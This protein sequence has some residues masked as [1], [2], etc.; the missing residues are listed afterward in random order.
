MKSKANWYV[1]ISITLLILAVTVAA[2]ACGGHNGA[3]SLDS[4]AVGDGATASGASKSTGV[5]IDEEQVA[6]LPA[7]Q[8][9]LLSDSGWNQPFI[10]PVPGTEIAAPTDE[11]LFE[12]TERELAKG[13]E[14]SP[15]AVDEGAS[16]GVDGGKTAS[17]NDQ[18]TFTP[19]VTVSPAEYA[20]YNG[21]GAPP[22][23]CN[24][25]ASNDYSS[26]GHGSEDAIRAYS[27]TINAS[28]CISYVLRGTAKNNYFVTGAA[29]GNNAANAVYQLMANS[30][31]S[32][33]KAPGKTDVFAE[34]SY[35]A[36][37]ALDPATSQP[38]AP[39]GS[40]P[41]AK[42]YQ[43]SGVYWLRFNSLFDALPGGATTELFNLLIAPKSEVSSEFTSSEKTIGTYQ[44]FY[45][46][47]QS[48]MYKNAWIVGLKSSTGGCATWQTMLTQN[49]TSGF[50]HRPIYGVLL[51]RW[52]D[53]ANPD[54]NGP[55]ES[56]FG[57]PVFG[58]V[59]LKSSPTLSSR[60]SYYA[61]GMWFERG[62]IWWI[63]YDQVRNPGT[64]DEAQAFLYTG[65]NV[66]C[67]DGEYTAVQPTLYYGANGKL[68]VGVSVDGMRYLGTDPWSP[69]PFST[70]N[71]R[72]EIPLEDDGM[73]TVSV[74]MHAQ[75]Y[76]GET[77]ASGKYKYYVW[78]FRDGLINPAGAAYND[79]NR[80]VQH[81]YGNSTRNLEG[82]YVVRVQ[83]TDAAFDNGHSAT[84]T[85]AYGDSFPIV[86]GHSPSG[87]SV[88]LLRN[89]GGTYATN[90]NA[91]KADLDLLK[92]A[93][94][95]FNYTEQAYSDTV[96]LSAASMVIWYRGGPAGN[97]GGA[98]D[99]R[100]IT[101]AEASKL[102]A[103]LQAGT[104]VLMF[105]QNAGISSSASWYIGAELQSPV[106][107]PSIPSGYTPQAW[108]AAVGWP[109]NSWSTSNICPVSGGRGTYGNG[110]ANYV[111]GSTV[112]GE[113]FTGTNSS[114]MIPSGFLINSSLASTGWQSSIYRRNAGT[115]IAGHEH[116]FGFDGDPCIISWGNTNAGT[117]N[118]TVTY[119]WNDISI[120]GSNPAGMTRWQLLQNIIAGLAP[121]AFSGGTGEA[122]EEYSGQPE[123]M[124]VQA[125]YYDATG[126]L[127]TGSIT[128]TYTAQTGY[129]G[130][131]Y[132]DQTGTNV[133]KTFDAGNPA[134][135]TDK[136]DANKAY[137]WT[138]NPHN[139][140]INGNDVDFQFPWYAYVCD[141]DGSLITG[142]V[143]GDEVLMDYAGL[144][145]EDPDD[146][147]QRDSIVAFSSNDF[148]A[149]A[150]WDPLKVRK[151]AGYYRTSL[152]LVTTPALD[153]S[154]KASYGTDMPSLVWNNEYPLMAEA[155]A[156]WDPADVA[157]PLMQWSVFPGHNMIIN[158]DLFPSTTNFIYDDFMA[159][160][161]IDPHQA[162]PSRITG[163]FNR[164]IF[165]QMSS[166][167]DGRYVKWD[168]QKS[169]ANWFA[170]FNM[171]GT[172][173]TKDKFPVRCRLLL[174]NTVTAPSVWPDHMYDPG[175]APA[176]GVASSN[177]FYVEGGCYVVD[178]GDK[179]VFLAIND[180]PTLPDPVA[181][182][183]Y[184]TGTN[185][186]EYDVTLSYVLTNVT[187][188][189]TVELD[190]NYNGVIFGSD[191]TQVYT[192][193]TGIIKD[194]PL[195]DTVTITQNTVGLFNFAIRVTDG[196]QS[197][198]Y[199][200]PDQVVLAGYAAT[201]PW[202]VVD[203]G[204]TPGSTALAANLLAISPDSAYGTMAADTISASNAVLNLSDAACF[205]VF[206]QYDVVIWNAGGAS[207]AC[208]LTD[209]QAKG[210]TEAMQNTNLIF[211]YFNQ[212]LATAAVAGTTNQQAFCRAVSGMNA[213]V[214]PATYTTAIQAIAPINTGPGGTVSVVTNSF[215]C[216]DVQNPSFAASSVQWGQESGWPT[217][218][219]ISWN[220]P[221]AG[222]GVF[223]AS[224]WNN[225]LA[226]SQQPLLF[227][228]LYRCD[229]VSYTPTSPALVVPYLENFDDGLAQ[230]WAGSGSPFTWIVGAPSTPGSYPAQSAPN[231]LR[232]S[233]QP[234]DY[235]GGSAS[236]SFDRGGRKI[237][238]AGNY[239]VRMYVSGARETCCDHQ[240]IYYYRNGT[241][242]NMIEVTNLTTVPTLVEY[243]MM[244]LAV[245]DVINVVI[246]FTADSSVNAYGPQIDTLSI[247][248]YT[249]PAPFWTE[250]FD[251]MPLGGTP[252]A[253]TPSGAQGTYGLDYRVAN[254]HGGSPTYNYWA[255]ISAGASGSAQWLSWPSV[256]SGS[257]SYYGDSVNRY[258]VS[259]AI[260]L[261]AHQNQTI[262]LGYWTCGYIESCCDTTYVGYNFSGAA[263]FTAYNSDAGN[264]GGATYGAW[265]YN[266]LSFNSGTNANVYVVI[267]FYSDSSVGYY[268]GP[269]FD[270]FS[271]IQ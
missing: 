252:T 93:G 69:V 87:G 176:S 240:Y 153:T 125:S 30:E 118:W 133:Y 76:G 10:D 168:F 55:W 127:H 24:A 241:L 115:F 82:T 249:P 134:D 77:N 6:S 184:N 248:L 269:Q 92:D 142:V 215:A 112:L 245:N 65:K 40:C 19:A 123:I 169:S 250:G 110:T 38:A 46:G 114:G 27:F 52:Q 22:F 64:P 39:G 66:Y 132:P 85:R 213:N 109:Y 223:L 200:Y 83:V 236:I 256:I 140:W 266:T 203:D 235:A 2:L 234:Y 122:F 207:N 262:T 166:D 106:A 103:T 151:V 186:K 163:P 32:N 9:E 126:A 148:V 96:N 239:R 179:I 147:W 217:Y 247:D 159:G 258:I 84:E 130:G 220:D 152:D 67:K 47:N 136:A 199:W 137:V 89:D 145:V 45:L 267:R 74:A 214:T 160:F 190:A 237:T 129:A 265:T 29:A 113:R 43:V 62:Y 172:I 154:I 120:T 171:D 246:S 143:S 260:S 88:I 230:G 193:H 56:N 117:L 104:P 238:T 211:F 54:M 146:V 12:Y 90:Y 192:A 13:L 94:V 141:V 150:G 254:Y 17:W 255:P 72:Y 243:T 221:G 107:S 15:R 3:I 75:A 233:A 242:M 20:T 156:H 202:L 60:G 35:R 144:P 100:Q 225:I 196:T 119:P 128:Y 98:Y 197:S 61:W 216:M 226:A 175:S 264:L 95:G 205:G 135:V 131:G 158:S 80:Y 162:V 68:S 53:A 210:A 7:W 194:G 219:T 139:D 182:T 177:G 108:C 71:L 149:L 195:T 97:A 218:R 124:G 91:L 224:N 44:E 178:T 165:A 4:S 59:A 16:T 33:P 70:D 164:T 51:A 8:Q 257:Y 57:W 263:S 253:W 99:N 11:M 170:D 187:S 204:D 191:P 231:V 86:I 157:A 101:A 183:V 138:G 121:A 229:P 31:K 23:G 261:A 79:T 58:P 102:V 198:V 50:Y 41:S 222:Q 81:T 268:G 36:D 116:G 173:N 25:N 271:L 228:M 161:D 188:P 78:A 1:R 180:D 18:G 201:S 270:N 227:N 208:A 244:S 189:S 209:M 48:G 63:D 259:P 42:S 251:A 73:D 5:L 49:A 37:K 155:L 212:R 34:L 185:P 26:K 181:T 21:T 232:L 174:N 105:F 28:Q 14:L 167:T 206:S 111:N